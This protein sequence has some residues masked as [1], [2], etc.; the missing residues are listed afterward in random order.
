[1]LAYIQ[2]KIY[3]LME[4]WIGFKFLVF[5]LLPEIGISGSMRAGYWS[6]LKK[7]MN[8]NENSTGF[9]NKIQI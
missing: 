5:L 1:M 8:G 4:D 9:S 6:R 2:S 7:V 3:K